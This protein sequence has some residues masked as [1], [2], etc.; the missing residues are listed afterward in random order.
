VSDESEGG[1]PPGLRK[2]N[3]EVY[4]GE[5]TIVTVGPAEIGFLKQQALVNPRKRSRLCAH[6]DTN[7]ALHE[8]LIVHTKETYVPPHKHLSKS[9]SFHIIEGE[10]DVVIFAEDGSIDK[11]ISMGLPQSGKAVFYRL[12]KP[13]YHAL[14]VRSAV[15]VFHEATN[16]PFRREETLFAPWAPAADDTKRAAHF[17]Q[18]LAKHIDAWLHDDARQHENS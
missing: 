4:Y 8:M 9:E 10:L 14:L 2:Q 5:G 15:V 7:D 11:V 6:P 1:L 13:C 17:M 18:E 12:Q 3:D 16:G